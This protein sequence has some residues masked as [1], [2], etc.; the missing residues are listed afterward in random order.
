MGAAE[1]S[2]KAGSAALAAKLLVAFERTTAAAPGRN[3]A[4]LRDGRLPVS[5]LGAVTAVDTLLCIGLIAIRVGAARDD[6]S[7]MRVA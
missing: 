4:A 5:T 3:A 2:A 1:M 7:T 6:A